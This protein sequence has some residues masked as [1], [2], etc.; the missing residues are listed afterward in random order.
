MSLIFEEET[1]KIRNVIFE[2]YNEVG[3]GFLENVYQECMEIELCKNEIPFE[4]QKEIN[5]YYKEQ[6]LAQIYKADLICFS[7][8]IIE[9]KAVRNLLSYH[10][11][12]IMNYLKAT[13]MKLG[14]LVNFGG[15]P[16]PEIKR[17]AN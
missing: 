12:Q 14:L 13:N 11:S 10:E 6:K 16:K 5:V 3:S 8:I 4:S 9:I 1:Y 2:V 15:Y 7:N 17:V